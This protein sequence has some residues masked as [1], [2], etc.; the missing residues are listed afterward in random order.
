MMFSVEQSVL[1]VIDVQGKLA[2]LMHQKEDLFRNIGRM[3]QAAQILEIPMVVTEQAPD[4]IGTTIPEIAVL[5]KNH[6]VIAKGSFS[7]YGQPDFLKKLKQLNRRQVIVSG[8]ETHVCVYQTVCDLLD[9][10]ME[11]QV[12]ADAVSSRTKGNKTV[13]LQRLRSLGAG[14]TTTE[15]I[16]C[17]LLKTCEHPGFRDVMGLIKQ[18]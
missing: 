3:I 1:L 18:V 12:V 6:Q 7:C 9:Q 10:G 13:A 16:L 8:I 17:E 4:K 2:H 15:M 5:L 11:V 14:V